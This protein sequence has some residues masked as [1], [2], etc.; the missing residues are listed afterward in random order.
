MNSE[1]RREVNIFEKICNI[2]CQS[3]S[4]STCSF[5]CII[6]TLKREI[7]SN[8]FGWKIVGINVWFLVQIMCGMWKDWKSRNSLNVVSSVCPFFSILFWTDFHSSQNS[9]STLGANADGCSIYSDGFILIQVRLSFSI[10]SSFCLSLYVT[11]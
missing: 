2:H 5:C 3:S 10:K 4:S 8:Y 7:A 9:T 1:M 6:R 11:I